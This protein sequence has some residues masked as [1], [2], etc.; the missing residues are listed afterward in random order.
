MVEKST[1]LTISIH[2]VNLVDCDSR[3][4]LHSIFAS[5]LCDGKL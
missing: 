4:G 2:W 3:A 5:K 1:Q